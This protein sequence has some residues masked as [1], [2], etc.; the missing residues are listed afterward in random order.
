[1]MESPHQPKK[2]IKTISPEE[3]KPDKVDVNDQQ[4]QPWDRLEITKEGTQLTIEIVNPNDAVKAAL[5]NVGQDDPGVLVDW[6]HAALEAAVQHANAAQPPLPAWLAGIAYPI[7][8]DQVKRGIM[9]TLASSGG[10]G[11]HHLGLSLLAPNTDII[12]VT[13]FLCRPLISC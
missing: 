13:A 12:R 6:H 9:T 5:K 3:S 2:K 8:V 4:E 1:M 7:T 11:G 10:G